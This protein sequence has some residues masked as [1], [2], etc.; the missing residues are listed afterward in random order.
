MYHVSKIAQIWKLK[1]RH[2]QIP[3]EGAAAWG[4]PSQ[5][6][7]AGL[8]AKAP[9]PVPGSTSHPLPPQAPAPW[10]HFGNCAQGHSLGA[11][12]TPLAGLGGAR[13]SGGAGGCRPDPTCRPRG[14]ALV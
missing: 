2:F 9:L 4:A 7:G 14:Q 8:S 1:A 11:G 6:P 5:A 10:R 12:H 13:G 3:G